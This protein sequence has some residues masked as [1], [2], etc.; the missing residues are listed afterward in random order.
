MSK[1]TFELLRE[2]QQGLQLIMES[3]KKP[4]AAEAERLLRIVGALLDRAL[5][6]ERGK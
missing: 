2:M 5:A 6:A 1:S 4:D 3:V